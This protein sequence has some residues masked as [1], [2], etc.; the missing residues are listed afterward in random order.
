[1]VDAASGYPHRVVLARDVMSREVLKDIGSGDRGRADLDPDALPNHRDTV[2]D[3]QGRLVGVVSEFDVIDRKGRTVGD[4][5][6]RKPITIRSPIGEAAEPFVGHRI[7]RRGGRLDR[8]SSFDRGTRLGRLEL[9]K[10][11]F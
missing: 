6:S 9:V 4:I 3:D 10:R 1:M 5:M 11:C 2:L 8:R 7:R